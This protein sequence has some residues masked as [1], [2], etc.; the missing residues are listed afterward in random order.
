MEVVGKIMGHSSIGITADIYR[1]VTTDEL[2]KAVE[3]Y[4]PQNSKLRT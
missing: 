1:N 4:G 3:K 2:H